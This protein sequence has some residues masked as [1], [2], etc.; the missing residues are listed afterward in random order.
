[1]SASAEQIRQGTA[2]VCG[3]SDG[4]R[5]PVFIF[6][7]RRKIAWPSAA[8]CPL[9]EVIEGIALAG[10]WMVNREGPVTLPA[11]LPSVRHPEPTLALSVTL[12]SVRL[13]QRMPKC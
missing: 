11:F 12:S 1:M 4:G 8:T 7:L 5:K 9:C 10:K 2:W 6:L 13:P 3:H